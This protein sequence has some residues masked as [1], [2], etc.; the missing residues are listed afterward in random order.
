MDNPLV[1]LLGFMVT[2]ATWLSP[3]PAFTEGLLVRYGPQWLVEHVAENRGYDLSPFPDRCGL[4]LMS[5]SDLGKIVWIQQA[6]GTWYG[7]CLA[8]DVAA[9]GDFYTV[10]YQYQEIAEV[11]N[12][13]SERMGFCCGQWGKVYIGVCPPTFGPEVEAELYRPPLA[14]DY[15]PFSVTPSM[16]P[17]PEQQYPEPCQ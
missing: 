16:W 14:K 2:V 3:Q 17:Y 7:P 10:I 15:P 1:A 11:P 4:S 8:M 9:R 13:V 6:D 5:P 12:H